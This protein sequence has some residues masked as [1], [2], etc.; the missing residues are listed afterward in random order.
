ME[1]VDEQEGRRVE[2]GIWMVKVGDKEQISGN[3]GRE[4]GNDGGGSFGQDWRK[5]EQRWAEGVNERNRWGVEGEMVENL[6]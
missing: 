3:V 4:E 5:E 1:R 2:R 6:G